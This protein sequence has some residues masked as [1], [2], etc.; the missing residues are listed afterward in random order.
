VVV[1]GATGTAAERESRYYMRT[2]RRQPL[3]LT[4]GQ[5][6]WVW[7]EQ[8][9][10]YLDLVAGIAVNVLGHCHPA[11]TEA[12]TRQAATLVHTSNL[13]YSLPQLDLAELLVEHSCADVVF[14]TNSGAESNE[15]AI[16]LARKYGKLHRDG[17]YEIITALNSF[18]GRTLATVAATGQPKY[19]APFA[20]MPEGF[21]HVPLNDIAALRAATTERT[22][23]VL[24]EPIQGESGVHPCDPD[25]LRAV[26]LWCDEQGLL[27]ILDEVQ[28]GMA[29]TGTFFAY[30]AYGVRPDI[31]TLAKGLCGGLPGGAV[32]ATERAAAF[33]PG[34]HGS[35][36]GGNPLACAAG[37][38]TVRTVLD[39]GLGA[40]A[41]EMGAYLS[42]GLTRLRDAGAPITAIRERGLMV[43]VDLATESA[44]AVVD[45]ARDRGALFNATG[46]A[47]LRMVPPL[48]LSHDEADYALEILATV[49]GE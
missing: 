44:A 15:A 6:C 22:V 14:F 24:L 48:I 19:Q 31:I 32:L 43:G 34:D 27:L 49:L 11:V 41:A 10:R 39:E 4:R 45:A 12:I 38:A 17:A 25:Y 9:K 23:A 1:T 18:H 29:R 37:V 33:T 2:F 7:D 26:R 3:V 20:P 28:T 16:K 36:L 40:H 5:G 46:P 42:A 30:E 8:G 35:T 21:T 47:T 13:Y